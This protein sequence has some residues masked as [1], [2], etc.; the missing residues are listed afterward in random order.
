[1]LTMVRT[2]SD[3]KFYLNGELKVTGSKGS[4]PSGDY[5]IGAWKTA[6]Q[7]N[8]RGYFS[9]ARIYST[10]LSSD[11][12]LQLYQVSA[13]IDNLGNIHE[14]E[15][16]EEANSQSKVLK[17]GEIKSNKF[18]E[19]YNFLYLPAGSFVASGLTY[20]NNDVCKAET[21]IRYAS[22]G[23]GRD[24]MGYSPSGQGY[25]GVTASGAW[26]RHGTFSYTNADITLPNLVSYEFSASNENGEYQI[27]ALRGSYSVRNKYIYNVKL[28]KNGILERD[29]YPAKSGSSIGLFDIK[30]GQ[31]YAANNSNATLGQD[32]ETYIAKFYPEHIKG[33][34]FIEI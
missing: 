13:K 20:A 2:S 14:Y 6:T 27:G 19:L 9:D 31:F 7:Q 30:N 21:V 8:Y 12:I 34:Q 5:F 4:F 29:L 16:I 15:L 23:S 17:T 18:V 32:D 24:L 11:D 22:G 28:Y 25:W 26:E 1:M 3:T 10:A 33:T